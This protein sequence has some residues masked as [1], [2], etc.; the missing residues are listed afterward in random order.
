MK[1]EK[2]ITQEASIKPSIENVMPFNEYRKTQPRILG[3]T[4]HIQNMSVS[5]DVILLFGGGRNFILSTLVDS[6]L[7][8]RIENVELFILNKCILIWFRDMNKGI[9][10]GYGN[11]IYHGANKFVGEE[12][13][14]GHKL[15]LIITVQ[16]DILLN[17]LF[18]ES[19]SEIKDSLDYSMKSIEFSFRPKYSVYDRYY[20]DETETLF[21]FQNFGVNRGDEMVN[22]SNEALANCLELT[23][24]EFINENGDDDEEEGTN[25]EDVEGYYHAN[26]GETMYMSFNDVMNTY[27]NSGNADDLDDDLMMNKHINKSDFDAGMSLEFNNDKR[28]IGQKRPN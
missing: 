21:T 10:L 13:R 19:D 2:V 23:G 9:E 16:R 18:P 14:D 26:Q 7:S 1:K 22:N 28:I 25:D 12:A 11:I 20:S 15:E 27:D 17:Q 8:R 24:N 5:D 4:H 6:S 3:E